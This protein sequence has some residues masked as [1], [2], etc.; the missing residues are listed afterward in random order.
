MIGTD[1]VAAPDD[2]FAADALFT[3]VEHPESPPTATAV[4]WKT[5]DVFAARVS[6][7]T[8]SVVPLN[9][10]AGAVVGVQGTPSWDTAG[11][12]G[13]AGTRVFGMASVKDVIVMEETCGFDTVSVYRTAWPRDTKAC[14]GAHAPVTLVTTQT[15]L[16]RPGAP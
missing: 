10:H 4:Y 7:D 5:L 9:T 15:D 16:T 14:E 3:T 1:A 13:F 6:P 2:P 12:V 8:L 11:P